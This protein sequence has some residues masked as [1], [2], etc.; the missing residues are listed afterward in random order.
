MTQVNDAIKMVMFHIH[1][2]MFRI[3]CIAVGQTT[4]NLRARC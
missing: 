1:N 3:D 4:K 2:G